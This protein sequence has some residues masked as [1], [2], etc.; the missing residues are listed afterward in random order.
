MVFDVLTITNNARIGRLKING[1]KLETP[2]LF[3]AISFFCGGTWQSKFGG[4]IYRTLK[5]EF[6][7][8][9]KFKEYFLGVMTSLAQV[10]DFPVSK[11]KF[12]KLYLR[13]PIPKWFNYDGVLFVDS[14]GF[15]LLT[16][17]GI[18]GRDFEIKDYKQVLYYQKKFG[19][20]IIVPL[21]YPISPDLS[22]REKEKRI[23]FSIRN[24][25]YLFSNKPKNTLAYLAI[26]GHSKEEL[27]YFLEK[28]LTGLEKGGVSFKKIDGIAIGS[29]V[30][31]R[32]NY[33]KIVDIVIACREILEEFDLYRLPLHVFGISSTLLP[34][35]IYLG[36]DT[37]DSASYIFAAINGVYYTSGLR[38]KHINDVKYFGNCNCPVCEDKIL[39]ER[40]KKVKKSSTK[41]Y[42]GPLAV[43]NLIKVQEEI[44]ILK[45]L[46]KSQDEVSLNKY[47][48][49]RYGKL[50]GIKKILEK[51]ITK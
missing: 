27:K 33:T 26:H 37:F 31:L 44:K 35:L 28:I 20:D 18:R 36:V 38:R 11:E 12:E 42:T 22:T 34:I 10:N 41:D 30:P 25:L 51:I 13:K 24:T 47:L 7:T 21:D 8:N 23:E 1:K 39:L 4:G 48:S 45:D 46:I 50:R 40:L 15:K 16:N 14:G 43:H 19:A 2:Y 29:L 9:P 49:M 5:E 3:P 32:S 6:L 17:G